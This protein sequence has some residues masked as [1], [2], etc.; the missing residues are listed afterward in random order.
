MTTARRVEFSGSNL[1]FVWAEVVLELTK[2]GIDEIAPL[3]VSIDGFDENG[4][5]HENE[6]IRK[7]LDELL[8]DQEQYDTDVVAFTIFPEKYWLMCDGDR[9]EFFELC[10]DAFPRIQD[11]A[12]RQNAR[13]LYVQRL[14]DFDG[15]SGLNQLKTMLD[16]YDVRPHA[17]R[18]KWQLTTFD[19]QRDLTT[20]ARLGFPC[21]QQI[22]F[23]FD[24]SGGL[25]MNAF[26]ATQQMLRKGY[27]NYLGLCRLGAFVARQM[28]RRMARLNV[29]IGVAQ[30]DS[31]K[32]MEALHKV[33]A[34][35]QAEREA[36]CIG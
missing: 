35:A 32:T 21:L 14:V 19:P 18:S 5:V 29:F 27:G 3:L 28:K 25:C 23:T 10:R 9:E 8:S 13:G 26:Y 15:K 30:M 33:L 20:S 31:P 6:A 12:P 4:V 7:A 2:R 11:F 34:I 16:E 22:S 24:G 17:R 36:E 1:S